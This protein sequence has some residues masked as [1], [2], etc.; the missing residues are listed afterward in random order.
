MTEIKNKEKIN[1]SNSEGREFAKELEKR[2]KKFA[3]RIIRLSA[4]LPNTRAEGRVIRTLI[5]R[6]EAPLV[7]I[8]AKQIGLGARQIL[9]A[10]SRYARVKQVKNSTGWKL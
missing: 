9:E 4:K 10:G 2:T 6:Q 3:V 1:R 5:T 8:A 7:P